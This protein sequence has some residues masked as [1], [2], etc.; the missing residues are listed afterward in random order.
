MAASQFLG[1]QARSSLDEKIVASIGA[2]LSISAVFFITDWLTNYTLA[3]TL[4]PSMGASAVLLLAVPHGTLSQPWPLFGGNVLVSLERVC[5]QRQPF[6]IF[7][8]ETPV[9]CATD[10]VL[11]DGK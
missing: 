9:Q 3:M 2:V 5:Y 4:L 7:R 8:H 6:W 1:I 11:A 10:S